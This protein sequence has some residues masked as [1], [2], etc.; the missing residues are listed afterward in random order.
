MVGKKINKDQSMGKQTFI[1]TFGLDL[2]KKKANDLIEEAIDILKVFG[3]ESDTL[4]KVTQ[5]V[6]S[7]TY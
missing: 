6:V 3:K 1:T 5:L 7:R 2:A 4:I